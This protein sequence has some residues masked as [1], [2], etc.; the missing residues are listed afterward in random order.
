MFQIHLILLDLNIYI[1]KVMAVWSCRACIVCCKVEMQWHVMCSMEV[2][3]N[4]SYKHY[5]QIYKVI[6]DKIQ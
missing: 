2:A 6:S 4:S 3:E 1:Y 5:L